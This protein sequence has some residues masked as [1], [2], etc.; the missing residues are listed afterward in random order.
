M[1][2]LIL[3][4]L[5]S[6]LA[7]LGCETAPPPPPPAE[8]WAFCGVHPDDPYAQKKANTMAQV[9]G[10]DSTLGTCLRPDLTTYTPTNPG[11]R[12]LDPTGYMRLL[13]INA[14]A[15]MKTVVY[16]ARIWSDDITARQ[17]AIDYWTPYLS[18]IR[19]WD[20]G[21]EFIPDT[22]DWKA[23]VWR[24]RNVV[25]YVTPVTGVGPYTNNIGG[26]AFLD[27]SLRDM[28]QQAN[29]YS[30]ALYTEGSN[31]EPLG[32][33]ETAALSQGRVSNLMCAINTLQ[34]GPYNPTADKVT[35][36]MRMA[37]DV[38]CD[39]FLIF[40]GEMPINTDGFTAQSLVTSKGGATP[41][42]AAVARGAA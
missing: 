29:H 6:I 26:K 11:Q 19:A 22:D 33:Y 8:T 12:Y 4:L 18:N 38:G 25:T 10:I 42:A 21:E 41:L 37:K 13:Q 16:D 36:Q 28:P 31:G 39:M 24:W 15:G 32:I 30:F 27:A 5:A 2:T 9:A 20:M 7:P 3:S 23:L 34:H 14:K 1:K 35:M 40:G 17:Q